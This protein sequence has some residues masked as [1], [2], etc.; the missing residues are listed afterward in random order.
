MKR[1]LPIAAKMFP[2]TRRRV[3][4]L[5]V[6]WA[7]LRTR[8]G[9]RVDVST[10]KTSHPSGNAA[11][12][13]DILEGTFRRFGQTHTSDPAKTWTAALPSERFALWLHGFS[14]LYHL[15]ASGGET[16][17]NLSEALFARWVAEYGQYHSF[18][19]RP[20]ILA[21]RVLALSIASPLGGDPEAGTAASLNRQATVLSRTHSRLPRSA[22]RLQGLIAVAAADLR[23]KGAPR[24]S[25][26]IRSELTETLKSDILPDGGHVSRCPETALD[27]YSDLFALD[28]LL[29]A[30]G[31]PAWPAVS[32]ALDRLAPFLATLS[33]TE[34]GLATFQGGGQGN[35]QALKSAMAQPQARPFGFAPNTGYQRIVAEGTCLLVDTGELPPF[36]LDRHAH[37]SPLAFE[38]SSGAGRLVVSCGFSQ[39]QPL[40]WREAV[41]LPAAHSTLHLDPAQ[42]VRFVPAQDV[43]SGL[44]IADEPAAHVIRDTAPVKAQR[45]EA[46]MGVLVEGSH[47]GYVAESGL[48]HS[49]RLYLSK[50]GRDLRGEDSLSLAPDALENIAETQ[51]VSIRFHLHPDVEAR[52]SDKGTHIDLALGEERWV[53]LASAPGARF[54]LEPSA[55]L[56]TGVRARPTQQIV[57]QL[58]LEETQWQGRWGLR[59]RS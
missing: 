24:L 32:R 45:R 6:D 27:I 52:L 19:W 49:R 41:Q 17:H 54:F 35:P 56:G 13:R 44:H 21:Q 53:F 47:H 9:K 20:D 33:H 22:A 2:A 50:D 37:V 14:W 25:A 51:T 30:E 39:E 12:G 43:F 3:E 11:L 38:M 23:L 40:S 46:E 57:M 58:A 48:I 34:G 26:N 42:P 28:G 5:R 15:A 10:A 55:Y 18:A 8:S 29:E 36:P 4:Q 1:R 16:A 31:K 7:G 59:R